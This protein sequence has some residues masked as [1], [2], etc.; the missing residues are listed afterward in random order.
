[1]FDKKKENFGLIS[2]K[3][4][5]FISKAQTLLAWIPNHLIALHYNSTQPFTPGPPFFRRNSLTQ[6]TLTPSHIETGRI[7]LRYIWLKMYLPEA[8]NKFTTYDQKT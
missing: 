3:I 7:L 5:A 4:L 8:F 6:C 2:A 1:L